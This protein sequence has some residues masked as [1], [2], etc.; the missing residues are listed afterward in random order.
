ML[1]DVEAVAEK[2]LRAAALAGFNK[3]QEETKALVGGTPASAAAE[4][5][6]EDDLKVAP[7]SAGVTAVA[8]TLHAPLSG[9]NAGTG[10]GAGTGAGASTKASAVD[11]ASVKAHVA[12][13][14]QADMEALILKKKK[15]A[16]LALY[17]SDTLKQKQ[18]EARH[19]LGVGAKR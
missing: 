3:R 19:L 8:T 13:P 12:V 7:A 5:D 15:E 9:T 11:D 16:M 1:I 6:D 4:D 18:T 17:S 2:R 10:T 14:T